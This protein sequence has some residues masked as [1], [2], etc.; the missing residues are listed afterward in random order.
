MG[1]R[2][3]GQQIQQLDIPSIAP[4]GDVGID[5]TLFLEAARPR[6][7]HVTVVVTVAPSNL[8]VW[9]ALAQ[10]VA[11]D[12]TD[13]IW[14]VHQDEYKTIPLGVIATALPVGTYHFITDGLGLYS[15][16]Y[17]QKSAGTID[18]TLSEI[19]DAERGS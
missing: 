11:D 19:L 8:T 5:L 12:L 9:G 6:W 17:F 18:V 15:K 16:L 10:G 1:K 13:D 7:W 14:G 3:L 4:V 2:I